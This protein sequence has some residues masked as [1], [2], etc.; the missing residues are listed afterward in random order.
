MSYSAFDLTPSHPRESG[1]ISLRPSLQGLDHIEVQ[2]KCRALNILFEKLPSL[3]TPQQIRKISHL[4]LFDEEVRETLYETMTKV[5]IVTGNHWDLFKNPDHGRHIFENPGIELWHKQVAIIQCAYKLNWTLHGD[6]E[7]DRK[8]SEM[9]AVLP[10]KSGAINDFIPCFGHV[11]DQLSDAERLWYFRLLSIYNKIPLQN[12]SDGFRRLFEESLT[13]EE[14]ERFFLCMRKTCIVEGYFGNVQF[15]LFA[16]ENLGIPSK[17]K[18]RAFARF[19]FEEGVATNTDLAF[20][21]QFSIGLQKMQQEENI[22]LK[23]ENSTLTK[24]KNIISLSSGTSPG[25]GALSKV[26][27]PTPF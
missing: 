26:F 19:A 13:E 10:P 17:V 22:R 18:Q 23:A 20:E 9:L 27:S 15:E 14:R 5:A 7:F 11:S 12:S 6:P 16:F 25:H 1:P 4:Y 21:L 8:V 2:A 24:L 3:T